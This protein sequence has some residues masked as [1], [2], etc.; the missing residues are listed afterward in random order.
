MNK[1]V[2]AFYT[3]DSTK[4]AS[5]GTKL[6]YKDPELWNRLTKVVRVKANDLFILFDEKINITV[7]ASTEM[8]IKK[9]LISGTIISQKQNQKLSPDL[10]LYLPI[11]KK[12]ALEYAFY[13]A[14]QMGANTIVPIKTERSVHELSEHTCERAHK[15]M[16][17]A[18]EQSKN[19]ILPELKEPVTL[20]QALEKLEQDTVKI[21][22]DEHGQELAS[23]LQTPIG[24]H[25]KK[26]NNKK[27]IVTLGPEAGFTQGEETLL[28][29]SGFLSYKLTPTILRSRE[30]LCLGLG[31]V[32][33]VAT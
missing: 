12:D 11:L 29:N 19:F 20:E 7:Q 28:K 18:C 3:Q 32:R 2:F 6:S 4:L 15:I 22:F 25:L 14:A 16:I 33:S 27:I 23:L 21:W 24:W 10:T 17:A 1:H 5:S 26:S 13:V 8:P 9:R 30:A 31:A